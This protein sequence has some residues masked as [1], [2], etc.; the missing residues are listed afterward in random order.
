[1]SQTGADTETTTPASPFAAATV[2]DDMVVTVTEAAR[3]KLIELRDEEP[4][5]DR[6]GVRIE[7]VSDEGRDFTYDLSFQIITKSDLSDVVRNHGGL[8]VIIPARDAPNLEGAT[9]DHEV[10]GLVLRNPNRPKPI[11]LGALVLDDEL[12]QRVAAI[13]DQEI[14]PALAAHGGYV[15]LLGHDGEGRAFLTMGGGCHG[16]AM[17][18]MTMLQGV[19]ASIK[20]AVP[21]I[22]KVIDAT[23][24]STGENPYY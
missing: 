6:L 2:D 16:C 17:S 20:E 11:Q 9:L 24:H 7:I 4:E 5:G 22:E 23:D 8:R 21:G 1:M 14:N 19:Q 3:S 18:R 15:T 12:G 10:D 13:I